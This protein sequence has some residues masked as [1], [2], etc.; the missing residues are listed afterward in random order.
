MIIYC[1]GK[2]GYYR[3]GMPKSLPLRTIVLTPFGEPSIFHRGVWM[4]Y[5]DVHFENLPVLC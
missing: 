4:L 1:R 3:G 2:M 5:G